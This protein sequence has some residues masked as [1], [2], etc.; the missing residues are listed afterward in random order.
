MYVPTQFSE[1]RL[2]VLHDFIRQARLGTLVT[3]GG[4]GL[5]AS[6]VPVLLDAGAD[7][8]G[9]LIGHLARANLQW[10]R[11]DPAVPAL[12]IFMGPDAYVSP[13]WYKTKQDTGKVVPTWNYAAVHAYGRLEFFDDPDRLRELVTSL[14]KMHEAGRAEPWAVSDAPEDFIRAQL[15]GFVGF[16]LSIDR[17]EGKWKMSQNR[18]AE[19]QAGVVAGLAQEDGDSERAV[20]AMMAAKP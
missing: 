19:D 11:T 20:A 6:H 17:I 10:R 16:R 13:G 2:P 3:L 7:A 4:E 1:D 8:N 15:K 12:M 14:T 9:A 18:S 5:E